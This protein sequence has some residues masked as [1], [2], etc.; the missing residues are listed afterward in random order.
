[1]Y[2]ELRK[3]REMFDLA[4]VKKKSRNVAATLKRNTAKHVF[5]SVG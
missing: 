5:S 4:V 1:M 2:L 3:E